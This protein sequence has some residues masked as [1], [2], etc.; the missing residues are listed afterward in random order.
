MADGLERFSGRVLLI[1]SGNDLTAQ[2]FNL[3]VDRSALWRQLVAA[4]RVAC[5]D[6]PPAD[7]TFST[8]AWRDQVTR[9]TA[10]W[11]RAP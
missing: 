6:L 2:E 9:W 8:R 4:E 11:V 3:V 1:R 10:D 5:R 7:H